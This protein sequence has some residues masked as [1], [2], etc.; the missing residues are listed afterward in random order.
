MAQIDRLIIALDEA[1][2]EPGASAPYE[3][4][5]VE[6]S[7]FFAFVGL[8][9]VAVRDPLADGAAAVLLTARGLHDAAYELSMTLGD[10]GEAIER[11]RR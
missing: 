9:N 6:W 2:D 3:R 1:R 11:G 8:I 10:L 5:L 7:R 4:L